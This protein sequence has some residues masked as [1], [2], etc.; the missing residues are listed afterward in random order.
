MRLSLKKESPYARVILVGIDQLIA[1]SNNFLVIWICLTTLP[2]EVFGSFSYSWSAIAL[3]VVLSRALFGIPALLD[4]DGDDSAQSI[5]VSA[6]LA[7]TLVLGVVTG[8]STLGLYLLGGTNASEV[9]IFGLFML[10]PL[11][12]FQD[13]IRYLLIASKRTKFAT[14]LDFLVLCCVLATAV[15]SKVVGFVG[16][17]LIFGLALGYLLTSLLFVFRTPIHLNI[18]NLQQFIRLD[19]HRRSRL[20]SDAFITWSFGLV[21]LTLIRVATGESG[22]A[23]YNGLVFLFGPVALVTVF[24]TIGLQSEVVRT[25]GNLAARHKVW[26]VLVSLSPILWLLMV[27]SAPQSF[28]EEFLGQSTPEILASAVPFGIA[29]ALGIGFEILNLF[30]RANEKFT[31]IAT[32]RLALGI[33]W[34]TFIAVSIPLDLQLDQIILALGVTN[35][36]GIIGTAVL[37]GIDKVSQKV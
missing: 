9:W 25:K 37:L 12:L 11:L 2:T 7:G 17:Y 13:Q 27:R 23:I 33:T 16:W 34:S 32:L 20:V 15:F 8:I 18:G 36:L 31:E 30:M 6:S 14:G 3:F 26:L 19:F 10:A 24:L 5:D 1:S 35:C 4:S 21:A 29:A 28:I 22:I